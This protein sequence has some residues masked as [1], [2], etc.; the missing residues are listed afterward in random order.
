[1]PVACQF[2]DLAAYTHEMKNPL[3]PLDR[4]Q[5]GPWSNSVHCGREKGTIFITRS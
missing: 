2:Y 1:M 3:C 4:G 5:G